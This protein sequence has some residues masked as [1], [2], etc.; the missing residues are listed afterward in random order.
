MVRINLDGGFNYKYGCSIFRSDI[1]ST[2]Y[3]VGWLVSI[4]LNLYKSYELKL[5]PVLI[6]DFAQIQEV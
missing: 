6:K 4:L 5:S 3:I 1:I 2:F